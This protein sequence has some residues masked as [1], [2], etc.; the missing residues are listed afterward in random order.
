M[1]FVEQDNLNFFKEFQSAN[2][3]KKVDNSNFNYIIDSF[4]KKNYDDEDDSNSG[5]MFGGLNSNKFIF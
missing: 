3:S 1:K 2:N 4:F 5:G